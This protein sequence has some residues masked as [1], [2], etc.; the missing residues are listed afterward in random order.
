MIVFGCSYNKTSKGLRLT[1]DSYAEISL[2]N[3]SVDYLQKISLDF[4]NDSANAL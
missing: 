4:E 2:R 3:K 1:D